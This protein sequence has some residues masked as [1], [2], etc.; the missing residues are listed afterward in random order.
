MEACGG[1]FESSFTSLCGFC[2]GFKAA[3]AGRGSERFTGSRICAGGL[4]RAVLSR[5][6]NCRYETLHVR[7]RAVSMTG[8]GMARL[9]L[10]V[11]L[12]APTGCG[13]RAGQQAPPLAEMK[14]GPQTPIAVKKEELGEPAWNRE[15]DK[16]VEDALPAEM[17]SARVARDVRPFCPRFNAISDGDK[18]AYWAYF[19][20]ALAGAEA[21]LAPTA[22]VRHA[23]PDGA[24]EDTVSKRRVRS[25]GLLQL[26]FMDA[27]RYGCDFDWDKDK[28]LPEKDPAKTILQPKNN[29]LCGVRIL[30]NQLI[31]QHKPLL[32]R[33]SYWATLRPGKSGYKVFLKQMANVPAV[34]RQAPSPGESQT[35]TARV[36][37]ASEAAR[38][39]ATG[40]Q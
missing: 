25:E 22:D 38:K 7:T 31:E 6:F 2:H 14:P 37:P 1:R 4:V 17:L 32:S 19:F 15:W 9:V 27:Q 16:I 12:W 21:G 10:C 20:Q 23:E 36:T 3:Q 39:A 30:Y 24:V 28:L 11:T 18:R 13:L 5:S 26:T 34:C 35:A 33:S 40:L 29:L 8:S